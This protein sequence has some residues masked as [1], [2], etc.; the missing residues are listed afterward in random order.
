MGDL[1]SSVSAAGQLADSKIAQ[2]LAGVA[3]ER[4]EGDGLGGPVS[5]SGE[6][7]G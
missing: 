7:G 5:W 1:G 6:S 4:A 2:G 3:S